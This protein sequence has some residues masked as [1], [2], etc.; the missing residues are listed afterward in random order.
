MTTNPSILSKTGR[1]PCE[2]LREIRAFIGADADLHVQVIAREAEA[3]A[4]EARAITGELGGTTYVKIPCIP[5]G[6]K[7]MRLLAGEGILT[8]GT[9][10]LTPMQAYLAA[11]SGASYVAPYINRIDTMGYDGIRAAKEIQ[12]MLEMNRCETAILAASFRNSQQ[13][14]ELCKYGVGAATVSP[15]VLDGLVSQASVTA[16][17][18]G[19]VQDFEKLAGQGKTM[20][21]CLKS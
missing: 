8:T 13:V 1:N 5:E 11:K 17:V 9:V 20:E 21:D 18:D 4:E 19:F 12:D 14:L 10:V 3:M 15:Q 16:A 2:V 6:F 7:A